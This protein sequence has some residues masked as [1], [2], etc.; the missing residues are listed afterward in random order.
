MTFFDQLESRYPRIVERPA[1]A[2]EI[3]TGIF[4]VYILTID[5]Q[6][7][8]VG[9]GKRNRARVIFDSETSI[10]ANHIK[11][12]TVRLHVLFAHEGAKYGWYLIQ[13]DS[14]EEAQEKEAALHREFGGNTLKLPEGIHENLFRDFAEDSPARMV[15]RM[16]LCSS[17]DGITDLKRWRRAGI[18]E[19]SIWGEITERLRLPFNV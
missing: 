1:D 2:S 4:Y 11:A 3:R 6:P 9:H 12:L 10:T 14:K 15:I 17:F 7:I 13:C 16:A 5:E 18:L 8:I 19:D